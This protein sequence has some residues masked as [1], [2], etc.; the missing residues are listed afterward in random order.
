MDESL[1]SRLTRTIVNTYKPIE[2]YQLVSESEQFSR[3]LMNQIELLERQDGKV[4][5]PTLEMIV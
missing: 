2:I 4:Y 3:L 1:T 5:F